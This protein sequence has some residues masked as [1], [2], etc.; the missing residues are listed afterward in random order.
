MQYQSCFISALNE[1]CTQ[2]KC[3]LKSRS[4]NVYTCCCRGMVCNAK[5]IYPDLNTSLMTPLLPMTTLDITKYTD[6]EESTMD[7][8]I[9]GVCVCVCTY[10]RFHTGFSLGGGGESM[11]ARVSNDSMKKYTP[12]IFKK[13]LHCC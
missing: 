2:D 7:T 4:G 1:P 9:P 12:G 11:L 3:V 8:T 6:G 5:L 10:F 13:W